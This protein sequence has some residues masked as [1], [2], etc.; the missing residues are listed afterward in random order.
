MDIV[1]STIALIVMMLFSLSISSCGHKV[2]GDLSH[3]SAAYEEDIIMDE[4][5]DN[6]YTPNDPIKKF[7]KVMFWINAALD[8]VILKPI[9]AIYGYFMPHAF[10]CMIYNFTSNLMMPFYSV[11]GLVSGDRMLFNHSTSRFMINSIFGI[12]GLV[13]IASKRYKIPEIYLNTAQVLHTHYKIKQGHYIMLPILGGS[14]GLYMISRLIELLLNPANIFMPLSMRISVF[15]VEM[16]HKR[17][18]V[19]DEMLEDVFD[20]YVTL[21]DM[22]MQYERNELLKK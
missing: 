17:W 18:E 8:T 10:K 3:Q 20:P 5:E 15:A 19:L 14:S 22:R 7:N 1:S 11:L 16:I 6:V 4:L 13:D 12:G 2:S 21:R 9:S